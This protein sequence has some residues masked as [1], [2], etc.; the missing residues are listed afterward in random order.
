MTKQFNSGLFWGL[1]VVAVAILWAGNNIA[2]SQWRNQNWGWH[3]HNMH[4]NLTAHF[5][6]Q[7]LNR[8]FMNT[9]EAASFLGFFESEFITL[10][11]DGQLNGTYVTFEM[12]RA[13]WEYQ[14]NYARFGDQMRYIGSYRTVYGPY[15]LRLFS[16]EK[17]TQWMLAQFE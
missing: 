11:E 16:R 8:E 3:N 15:D 14:P 9:S 1:C 12:Q 13:R 10:V 2:N 17:L 7:Y 4:G 6:D 5:V